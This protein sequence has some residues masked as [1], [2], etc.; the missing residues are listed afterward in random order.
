MLFAF[1]F[2]FAVGL[3]AIPWLRK[4]RYINQSVLWIIGLEF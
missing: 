4:F 2:F 1:N 3:L